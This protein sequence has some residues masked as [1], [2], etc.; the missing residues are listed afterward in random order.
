VAGTGRRGR[1][2]GG[3]LWARVCFVLLCVVVGVRQ[4][5]LLFAPSP[6]IE[7]HGRKEILFDRFADGTPVGQTFRMLSDGL[8]DVDLQFATDRPASV[9]IRY[10]LMTWNEFAGG[11]RILYQKLA[12]HGLPAGRTW[13]RFEFPPVV[14]SDR[15]VFLFQVEQIDVHPLDEA[16]AAGPLQVRLVGFE[17]EALKEGNAIVGQ[18]QVVDRDLAFSAGSSDSAFAHYARGINRYLPHRLQKPGVQ[19]LILAGYSVLLA[20]FAYQMVFTASARRGP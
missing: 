12:T 5:V 16:A 8:N 9:A 18:R 17:D 10:Q 20:A 13:L 11:W 15:K 2:S 7:A 3:Q 19:L 4:V 14:P 6:R 1:V